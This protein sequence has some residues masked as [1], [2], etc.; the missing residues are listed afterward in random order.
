VVAGAASA[1]AFLLVLAPWLARDL[2]VFGAPFPSA[3]GHTLWITDYNEQ[4]SIS[5]DP[6][7]AT[8]FAA[9]IGTVVGSKLASWG[10]L[11]GRVAVLM[12]GFFILPFGW[13]LW[14]ERRRRELAPF[15]VYFLVVFVVM[16]LVF[17]FH[18]P[19]GAFYHSAA[20]WLPFAFPLAVASLP[21]LADAV[22]RWWPFL[23]RPATHRFL[24]VAGLVGAGVL[25]LVGSAA[26]LSQWN[27]AHARLALAASFLRD[28]GA[29]ADRVLAYDPAALHFL[30]GNPGVAP[31]FDG[32]DV[33]GEVVDAYDVRWVVV[34]L[35]PGETRDPLGLWDGASGTDATGQH[36][37]FLPVTPEFEASGVRVFRVE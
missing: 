3:G 1:A 4:F 30:T 5:R 17:T 35:A 18:A 37:D 23:R 24:L 11:A 6:S 31:P 33:I 9:G 21:G 7:P 10:E 8:Y 25:S 34:T 2:A 15:L 27:A 12:G 29:T 16:G 32:F 26:L 22:G 28:Q 13:G 19:K 20:A 36:P 14:A